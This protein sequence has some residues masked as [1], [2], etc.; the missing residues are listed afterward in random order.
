MKCAGIA[1]FLATV[2]VGCGGNSNNPPSPPTYQN[3]AGTWNFSGYSTSLGYQLSGTTTIQQSGNS[4][5]GTTTLN[6]APCAT[7]GN[8]SGTLSGY[9]LTKSSTWTAAMS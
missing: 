6:G 3:M 2:L 9:N 4:L 8:V 5:T 7:P 1:I